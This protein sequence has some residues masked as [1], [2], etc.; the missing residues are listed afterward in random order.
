MEA[1]MTT[2]AGLFP[3]FFLYVLFLIVAILIIVKVT[4]EGTLSFGK[5]KLTFKNRDD[6][7]IRQELFQEGLAYREYTAK[8][9]KEVYVIAY[10]EKPQRA[11][12]IRK[13]MVATYVAEVSR[14]FITT[15]E[16]KAKEKGANDTELQRDINRVQLV[17]KLMDYVV[18]DKL[19]EVTVKNHFARGNDAEYEKKIAEWQAALE[20]DLRIEID[21]NHPY[22]N[23]TFTESQ[24]IKASVKEHYI[25]IL[26]DLMRRSRAAALDSNERIG[27]LRK[28]IELID[29][30]YAE[31]TPIRAKTLNDWKQAGWDGWREEIVKNKNLIYEV[32]A[33]I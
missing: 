10:Q 33:L 4:K 18:R 1:L 17:T 6:G 3:E 23:I 20:A 15:L 24:E 9:E 21:M 8:L 30:A 19:T 13:E 25:K 14:R 2:L 12:Q 29:R 16:A 5:A 22:D 7:A 32:E 27:A 31:G 26:T 11:E 28:A